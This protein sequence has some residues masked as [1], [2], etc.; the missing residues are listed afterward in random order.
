VG[1]RIPLERWI[2]AEG[3]QPVAA[4]FRVDCIAQRLLAGL[5]L[6]L[7]R[8]L[9]T[10]GRELGECRAGGPSKPRDREENN[11]DTQPD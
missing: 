2:D 1:S 5:E 8:R 4:P 3:R 9:T 7:A 10:R 11:R 6:E